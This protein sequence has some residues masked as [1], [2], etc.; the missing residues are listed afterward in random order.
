MTDP[1]VIDMYVGGRAG[2]VALGR[3]VRRREPRHRGGVRERPEGERRGHRPRRG[4]GAHGARGRVAHDRGARPRLDARQA[5]AAARGADPR[6]RRGRDGAQRQ[7]AVRRRLRHARHRRVLR[8]LRRRGDQVR[9]V[10][11]PGPGRLPPLHAPRAGRRLR[12][13]RPVELPARDRRVEDRA[14]ARGRV[15][16]HR[17]AGERDA[18]HRADARRPGRGGRVP[19]GRLQRRD[20]PG[21]RGGQRA[22]RAPGRRQDLDHRR[23]LDRQDDHARPAPRR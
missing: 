5:R 6:V 18:G 20:R 4:G 2:A 22:R 16:G 17:E 9:R 15:H 14:G 10:H 7:D 12:P 19:G 23:D 13:D 3:A 11:D 8:L 21:A 1:I